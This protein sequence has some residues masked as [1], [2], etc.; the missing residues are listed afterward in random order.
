MK[1]SNIL[2]LILVL[3]TCGWF[4][5]GWHLG[6]R[7]MEVPL[8]IRQ[9]LNNLVNLSTERHADTLYYYLNNKKLNFYGIVEKK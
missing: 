3:W 6:Q 9:D 5:L 1:I 4:Y 2:P 7:D 8:T